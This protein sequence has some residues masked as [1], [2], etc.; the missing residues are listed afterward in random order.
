MTLGE[1]KEHITHL[2]REQREEM[3]AF[4]VELNADDPNADDPDAGDPDVGDDLS[5]LWDEAITR[6]SRELDEGLVEPI[7]WHVARERMRKARIDRR[8]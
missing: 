2:T 1:V 6:R 3:E 8:G 7:P 5:R 4:L